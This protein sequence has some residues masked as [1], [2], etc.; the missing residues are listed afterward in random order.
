MRKESAKYIGPIF[1]AVLTAMLL[2]S[3]GGG[4]GG[5]GMVAFSNNSELHN[6]GDAGGWGNGHQTSNN[7]LNGGS[8]NSSL[9]T[10]AGTFTP[11]ND[12]NWSSIELTITVTSGGTTTTHTLANTETE[13]IAQLLT[14]LKRGDVV[15]VTADII[16][17]DDD[18]RTTSSG[19]VTIGVGDN[20]ISLP[21]PYKFECSTEMTENMYESYYDTLGLSAPIPSSTFSGEGFGI[22]TI[23]EIASKLP[24]A[25]APGFK[26]DH[27]ITQDSQTY[28]PGVTRGDVVISPVFKP[29]YTCAYTELIS[30]IVITEQQDFNDLIN[31]HAAQDFSGKTITLNCDVSTSTMFSNTTDGFKG[32]L[33]GKDHTVQVSISTSAAYYGAELSGLFARNSS[34]GNIHNLITA[35]S[36]SGSGGSQGYAGG[37]V[38]RNDGGIVTACANRA[39][40][41]GAA[42]KVGGIAGYN[43]GTISEC[44]NTGTIRT[45]HDLQ[46]DAG[47]ITGYNNN[48]IT[49][50]Y[51][52]GAIYGYN[53]DSRTGGI[54]GHTG[55]GGSS[56]T[57][58]YCYST[59]L[60]PVSIPWS[61]GMLAGTTTVGTT[62]AD[63]FYYDDT[64]TLLG[65]GGGSLVSETNISTL[66]DVNNLLTDRPSIWQAGSPYPTL[67]NAPY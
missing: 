3:C 51:N 41:S 66:A 53:N 42:G 48:T 44:Y 60:P 9:S 7:G 39:S 1:L 29:D 54:T 5:G 19:A 30:D 16:M 36:V 11:P 20:R 38:G 63:H 6:G 62:S 21:T 40:V 55:S 50:C 52:T 17:V 23:N 56:A 59:F 67:I 15:E 26:F 57:I 49:D 58:S 43:S 27:W 32:E 37:I 13:A 10:N 25:T 18:P 4:G 47:G 22:S 64:R 35:G 65:A 61:Y 28:I 12:I 34:T 14:S 2:V 8:T 33:D 31:T 46:A 24:E 45:S